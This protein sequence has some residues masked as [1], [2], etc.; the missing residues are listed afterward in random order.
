MVKGRQFSKDFATDISSAYIINEAM[1]KKMAVESII[2]TDFTFW[3]WPGKI[4]GV[5]KNFHFRSLKSE[6][7]P[8]ALMLKKENSWNFRY[9]L[10]RLNSENI[11]STTEFIKESWNKIV[12][13]YPLEYNFIDEDISSMYTEERRMGELVKYSAILAVFVACLGL[14]GL[15]SFTVDKRKKEIGI[16]KVLG[17]SIP[18][19]I[20][21][22]SREFIILIIISNIAAWS[23]AYFIMKQWLNNFPYRIELGIGI[24]VLS[25]IS[26]LILILFSVS[27]QAVK[28]ATAN[29]VDSLR[30]E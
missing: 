17:A 15:V 19:I 12:P 3:N 28:A 13:D 23:S 7:Q 27:Y 22:L 5:V 29:P 10:L 30:Y 11:A 4:I 14:F 8:M 6:I 18:T 2:G 24:F 16:R 20:R 21:L 1:A 9:I 26:A 25:G